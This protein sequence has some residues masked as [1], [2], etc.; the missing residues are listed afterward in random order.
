MITPKSL[1]EFVA[2]IWWNNKQLIIWFF[3]RVS[4]KLIGCRAIVHVVSVENI[5]DY[6]T[7]LCVHMNKFCFLISYSLNQKCPQYMYMFLSEWLYVTRY[8]EWILSYTIIAAYSLNDKVHMILNNAF[9]YAK[10]ATDSANDW[11]DEY[12][13]HNQIYVVMVLA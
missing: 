11:C 3:R 6:I 12:V 1:I 7:L 9:N 10:N 5:N 8:V 2:L 13:N 4:L